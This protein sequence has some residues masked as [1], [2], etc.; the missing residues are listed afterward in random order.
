MRVLTHFV[1]WNLG[2]AKAETQTSAAERD[3][4]CRHV[5]GRKRVVEIGVWHGVTTKRLRAAMAS[6]GV[7]FG[8]DPFAKGRLRFSA[9]R[10]IARKEVGR[11]QNGSVQWVRSTGAAAAHK[12]SALDSGPV[13]FVF[14][15]GDHTFD[16]LREDWEA[17]SP[18]VCEGGIVALHDSCSSLERQIDDAGSVQYTNKVIKSDPRFELVESVD[19]LTIFRRVT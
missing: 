9:H 18:L 11:I 15:D 8:V 4:L 1:F 10:Y 17:W 2:L 6:E 3:C 7:L 16:G 14:I 12:H 19:T 13:D 5:T